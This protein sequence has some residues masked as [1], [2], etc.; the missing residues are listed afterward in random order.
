MCH[1][2]VEVGRW[3]VCEEGLRD[4]V[5]RW[6]GGKKLKKKKCPC[7]EIPLRPDISKSSSAFYFIFLR[8]VA[9][10]RHDLGPSGETGAWRGG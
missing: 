2:K 10:R 7:R 9:C 5:G 6:G 4:R 1:C 3:G 8:G